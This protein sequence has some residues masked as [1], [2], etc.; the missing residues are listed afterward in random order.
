MKRSIEAALIIVGVGAIAVTTLQMA[1]EFFTYEDITICCLSVIMGA[2]LHKI[3]RLKMRNQY[4]SNEL[5]FQRERKDEGEFIEDFIREK[6]KEQHENIDHL[7]DVKF[8]ENEKTKK[9]GVS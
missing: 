5:D 1:A 9:T 7:I 6:F 4:L 2:L 3:H 8:N